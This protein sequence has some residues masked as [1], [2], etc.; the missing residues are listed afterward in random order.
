MQYGAHFEDV[1]STQQ[2]MEAA[3]FRVSQAGLHTV[4]ARFERCERYE[5]FLRTVVLR[6]PM[7]KLPGDL[8]EKFLQEI[9]RHT[10]QEEGGY[11]LDYVR[12][13]VRAGS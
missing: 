3:G 2:R 1:E 13:T 8:Q 11:V 6:Q 9:S 10:F 12:L 5:A 4:E 7:A